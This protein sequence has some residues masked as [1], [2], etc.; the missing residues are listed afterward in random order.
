MSITISTKHLVE[1]LSDLVLT[2][3]AYRG[4]HIRT[5]R[6]YWGEDPGEVALL[7]GTSTNGHTVGHTWTLCNGELPALVWPLADCRMVIACL[8]PIAAANKLHTVTISKDGKSIII[9]E[10]PDL[11]DGGTELRFDGIDAE[12]FPIEKLARI[13]TGGTLPTPMDEERNPVADS[14]RTTWVSDALEPLL[15]IANRR[16]EQ[17]HLFRIH[18]LQLHRAQIG[19]RWIGAVAPSRPYGHDDPDKPNADTNFGD[20]VIT[21][22]VSDADTEWLSKFG[23]LLPEHKPDKTTTV[24]ADNEPTLPQEPSD[25]LVQAANLVVTT[26]F[27]ASSM[28]QRKL[29]IGFAKAGSLLD[30]LE[31]LGIVGP[32]DGTKARDVLLT[33]GEAAEVL[34]AQDDTTSDD[35]HERPSF[36]S[37]DE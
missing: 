34:A 25:L 23:I 20:S 36:S 9:A 15:K 32:A 26:Q 17:L 33:P 13:L 10:S 6:G 29:K 14:A 18:S 31:R 8:K 4:I 3:D 19:P 30:E 12:E 16:K 5:T 1:I 28:L 2:A 21:E 27:A 7:V 22:S 24:V 37:G 35:E 11:F